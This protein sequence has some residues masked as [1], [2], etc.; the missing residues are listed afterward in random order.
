MADT[1]VESIAS[2]SDPIAPDSSSVIADDAGVGA[3]GRLLCEFAKSSVSVFL[4][5][6]FPALSSQEVR[7]GR[8]GL[9]R[10]QRQA[11]QTTLRGSSRLR[12]SIRSESK[13][14]SSRLSGSTRRSWNWVASSRGETCKSEDVRTRRDH[15]PADCLK[16]CRWTD[17]RG[18]LGDVRVDP[19]SLESETLSQL[20]T[21][22]WNPTSRGAT[23]N[24]RILPFVNAFAAIHQDR[25]TSSWNNGTAYS[26]HHCFLVVSSRCVELRLR[27]VQ[28]YYAAAMTRC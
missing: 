8:A 19:E 3:A 7:R 14:S 13:P 12:A 10:K 1:A 11:L 16:A 20:N 15:R 4:V 25:R 2:F 5:R 24:L 22:T 26:S 21:F 6:H 9:C 23:C 18:C 27:T 17:V 28:M